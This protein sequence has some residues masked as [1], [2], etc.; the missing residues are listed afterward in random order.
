MGREVG[1][2]PSFVG[3]CVASGPLWAA[4]DCPLSIQAYH[5]IWD[6]GPFCTKKCPL[7]PREWPGA[8]VGVRGNSHRARYTSHPLNSAPVQCRNGVSPLLS[9]ARN[10]ILRVAGLPVGPQSFLCSCPGSRAETRPQGSP[11]LL[12]EASV[13]QMQGP[14]KGAWGVLGD[15]KLRQGGDRSQQELG[16]TSGE[17]E[18]SFPASV[19]LRGRVWWSRGPG[20]AEGWIF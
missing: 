16:V 1:A 2:T 6:S 14:E 7:P 13:G 20:A 11:L 18:P 9:T 12:A 19:L 5:Q 8:L 4:A 15:T 3:R 10:L 17:Q